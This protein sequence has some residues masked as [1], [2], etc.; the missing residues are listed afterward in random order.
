MPDAKMDLR[1]KLASI[2][3]EVHNI[4]KGGRNEHFNYDYVTGADIQGI[5][6]TRLAALNI[7]VARRNMVITKHVIE[8]EK[9]GAKHITG[10]QL[11]YGYLDGETGQ[12][13]WN[14]AYGEGEDASDK[15]S[16]KAQTGAFKYHLIQT[17]CL[18]MGDD[19]EDEGRGSRKPVVK[20]DGGLLDDEEP[21]SKREKV[22]AEESQVTAQVLS[23]G[24]AVLA[25]KILAAL[26][27]L[28]QPAI[29]ADAT[30]K[31]GAVKGW[32]QAQ[33][34]KRYGYLV[35]QAKKAAGDDV[36]RVKIVENAEVPF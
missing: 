29:V 36:E 28:D 4:E 33:F 1:A 9:K 5:I 11:E 22:T 24:Q 3:R 7:T 26:V 14:A 35:T 27:T 31:W 19:P 25:T 2:R 6:G 15:G 16:F 21:P 10:V 18:A 20:D 8:T 32:P 17:F 34:D 23:E 30:A 12:E 13:L